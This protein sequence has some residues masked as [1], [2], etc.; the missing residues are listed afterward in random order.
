MLNHSAMSTVL[1]A[2]PC[3]LDI[4]RHSPSIL[5]LLSVMQ[6]EMSGILT[7]DYHN[8]LYE[9]NIVGGKHHGLCP[10]RSAVQSF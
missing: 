2:L 6:Q 9:Q 1:E 10:V 4:K 3:K 8:R 7:F 5:Y